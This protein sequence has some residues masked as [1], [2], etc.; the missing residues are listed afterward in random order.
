MSLPFVGQKQIVL[1]AFFFK[2]ILKLRY[3]YM[4]IN[5]RI[6]W[7]TVAFFFFSKTRSI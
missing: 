1:A 6:I 4:H 2:L 7:E 3:C 5:V